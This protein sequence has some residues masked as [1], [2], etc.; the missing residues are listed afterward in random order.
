ME[1]GQ[2]EDA[3]R[4]QRRRL[5]AVEASAAD[6][7][8]SLRTALAVAQAHAVGEIEQTRGRREELLLAKADVAILQA[9]AKV[10]DEVLQSKYA[11]LQAKGAV[12]Q[13]KESVMQPQ[14]E[15]LQ[16]KDAET[17]SDLH[18]VSKQHGQVYFVAMTHH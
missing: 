12:I 3:G 15:L 2:E 1:K 11:L 18:G 5:N 13:S 14:D 6:E 8:R 17:Q 7:T 16:A 4:E 10:E 9:D